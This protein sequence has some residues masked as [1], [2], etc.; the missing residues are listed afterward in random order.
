M[1]IPRSEIDLF[2]DETL[3]HTPAQYKKLRELGA[4][5]H[6]PASDLYAVTHFDAVR[7]ALRADDVLISGKGVA[8][9]DIINSAA[10]EAT[11]TSDG[12]THKHRR[13]ILMRPLMPKSLDAVRQ[14]VEETAEALV[15]DLVTRD[16][17]CGVKDFASHLPLS[18]VA[19]L[20]GLEESGRENMLD[21]AA[22]TF[23]VLGPM[24]DR[25][26]S[27]LQ[28][29][30]GLLQYVQELGPDRV[31]DGGWAQAILKAFEDGEITE[32][33][34]AM[35][36][37]DYTAPS[38]DTTILASA[39]MLWRL[40]E[41]P[42]AFD[43]LKENPDLIPSAVNESVRLA[44][45]IRGFTRF[46]QSEYETED[47]VIPSGARV[48]VLYASANWD[49]RHYENADAFQVDR[50][51]RDHVGWGHGAHTCAGMH[52]ARLEME[53]LLRALVRHVKSIETEEPIPIMNNVLQGFASLPVR[54]R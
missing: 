50:N 15:Q 54:F 8:A 4:I 48:A 42:G 11:L 43:A 40:G 23:D 28:R 41:T 32:G 10:N 33:E 44:S 18:I 45:P 1:S 37:V 38:L 19:E 49:E 24:N 16:Q 53:A 26:T 12:E 51:P 36:V 31:R 52:L 17:F 14:R 47:G 21:W 34:A 25:T 6:V 2:S 7:A 13:I 35:M 30:F 27:A 5:V 9:N 39:H 3:T 20:V 22:A 29:A 46:A